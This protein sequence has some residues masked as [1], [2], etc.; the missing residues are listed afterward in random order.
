METNSNNASVTALR[1]SAD[2]GNDDHANASQNRELPRADDM[3]ETKTFS[4]DWPAANG[5]A[6]PYPRSGPAT[7]AGDGRDGRADGEAATES[8]TE[9]AAL[10]HL[11]AG[12]LGA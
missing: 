7:T 3:D 8:R 6:Q 4:F 11:V 9:P 2:A 1:P 10:G 12:I 5:I